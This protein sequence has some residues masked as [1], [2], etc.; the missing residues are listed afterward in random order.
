MEERNSELADYFEFV[1]RL[2]DF[3]AVIATGS[4]NSSRYFEAYFGKYPNIIRKN[5]NAV[6]ILNGKESR[7]QLLALGND[8]FSIFWP[9]VVEMFLSCICPKAL[10]LNLF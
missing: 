2:E 8:V 5:R 9:G 7:E 6:A 4:N 10:I 3:D 1:E